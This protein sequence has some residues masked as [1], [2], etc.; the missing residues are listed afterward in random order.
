MNKKF[1]TLSILLIISRSFDFV[2]TYIYTP[3][4]M[5]E[6]NILVNVFHLNYI[7]LF[8]IQFV[9]LTFVIW[10]LFY[11]TNDKYKIN[12]TDKVLSLSKF[13]PYFHYGSEQKFTAFFYK[14]PNFLSIIYSLGYIV[15]NVLIYI[16]F[17]VGTSTTLLITFESYKK[18]YKNGG[19]YIAYCLIL[20]LVILFT[21][22]FYKIEY[23]KINNRC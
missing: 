13:I 14:T 2:T 20:L 1:I 7:G 3:D 19:S 6:T 8:I 5:N 4:L 12:K 10:C 17:I 16:G 23:K 9:L 21:I 18:I 11:Y 22:R 15:T